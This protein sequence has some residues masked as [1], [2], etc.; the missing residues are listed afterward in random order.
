MLS[1][2]LRRAGS[3]PRAL[4]ALCAATFLLGAFA[5]PASAQTL[6]AI[7]IA[8]TNDPSIG[9]S[10]KKDFESLKRTLQAA[11]GYTGMK[12]ELQALEGN[13][14]TLANVRAAVQAVKTG[15]NDT[16][17]FY[18]SGHG[19]RT[20]NSKSRY[21]YLY[22]SQQG[23]AFEE[24]VAE[25]RKKTPRL[26]IAVT[27]SC[28]NEADLPVAAAMRS[29]SAPPD[30]KKT[31][32]RLW[33]D[34]AGEIVIA[35]SKEGEYAWGDDDV[36]GYFT[37]RFLESHENQVQTSSPTVTP[38]WENIIA[39]AKNVITV[40]FGGTTYTQTP[41]V[42]AKVSYVRP[43]VPA[44]GPT[45]VAAPTP[46]ATLPPPAAAAAKLSWV[47]GNVSTPRPATALVAGQ[48]GG[49]PVGICHAA[50]QGG[51]HPG[52]LLGNNGCSIGYAGKEVLLPQYEVLT[53]DPKLASW[54][55]ATGGQSAPGAYVGGGEPGRPQLVVC[56]APIPNSNN[57]IAGKLVAQFC[58]ISAGGREIQAPQY[59]VLVAK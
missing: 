55:R 51:V 2:I 5:V 29:M 50:F 10:V 3:L 48:E 39:T 53:G 31:Y 4:A 28:N 38:G 52:K 41:I 23:Q 37:K 26:L 44:G 12:L 34:A 16:V 43:Y 14:V 17:F 15:P 33:L 25:L 47:A 13:Q 11:A 27:D 6:Q 58:N 57:V 22:V 45:V 21:P 20:P 24:I 18:Y 32:S 30:Y 1:I 35:S 49:L 42:D 8:D 7:L 59:E 36:G 56:R 19:F 9:V 46:G 40:P 54:V